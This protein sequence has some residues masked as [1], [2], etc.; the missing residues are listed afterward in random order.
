MLRARA[1]AVALLIFAICLTSFAVA[2]ALG[3]GPGA[4]TVELAVYQAFRFE[5]DL[6]KAA[7]LALIQFGLAALAAT[8]AALTAR[9]VNFGTGLRDALP[10]WDGKGWAALV[11]DYGWITLAALFLLGPLSAVVVQGSIGLFSL[12]SGV[13]MALVNSLIV[14]LG[15]VVVTVG[16]AVPLALACSQRPA[17]IDG[18]AA[19]ALA[20]SPLV[21]GTGLYVLLFPLVAPERVAL[22]VTMAVNAALSLPFALRALTPAARDLALGYARLSE[23][24]GMQRWARFRL[25]TV[26][27]L[28]APLGFAAG[29]TA[30]LSMGD[31][32]VIA[33]FADADRATLPLQMYRLMGAYRGSE[34]AGAALLLLMTSLGLFVAFEGWGRGRAA[35]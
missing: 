20:A 13:W 30:A 1:P 3:G 14:S 22:P 11:L 7:Q 27:V 32:G 10:R 24:L 21:V 16:L 33:L 17:M 19:V 25:V 31:L 15:C 8:L 28:R 18:L 35:T 5:A 23:S 26:P 2:L 6:G 9:Q 34:A 29:L 4:T 12:S